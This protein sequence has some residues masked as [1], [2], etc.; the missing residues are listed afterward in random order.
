MP[1]LDPSETRR[2]I[3]SSAAAMFAQHGYNATAM[4]DVSHLAEVNA[5]T[6]FR[7][8]SRKLDLYLAA[9]DAKLGSV[10]L[11]RR[12]IAQMSGAKN[13]R[14]ALVRTLQ[15]IKAAF[16]S[17]PL[18]LRL[19]QFGML[20]LPEEIRPLLRRHL[21]GLLEISA[22]SLSPWVARGEADRKA[23]VL[24][25]L[26]VLMNYPLLS[27]LFEADL[28]PP[29]NTFFLCAELCRPEPEMKQTEPAWD[30][31]LSPDS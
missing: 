27:G 8:F 6:L 24:T 19:L 23:I 16:E 5:S 21:K 9:L 13:S 11:S 26:A 7:H 20:E 29:L 28:L 15:A 18:L 3:L 1:N 17:D 4:H 10:R 12:S 30:A 22:Q 14:T 31:H 25:F 2:R